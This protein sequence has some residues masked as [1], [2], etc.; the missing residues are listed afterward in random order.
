MPL[1]R[2]REGPYTCM[3]VLEACCALCVI[4]I[5]E[6][7]SNSRARGVVITREAVVGALRELRF[8][9]PSFP[10][11]A[12]VIGAS[13]YHSTVCSQYERWR[14]WPAVLRTL[15]LDRVRDTIDGDQIP[16]EGFWF[17]GD[18]ALPEV[19]NKDEMDQDLTTEAEVALDSRAEFRTSLQEAQAAGAHWILT[20]AGEVALSSWLGKPPAW[21]DRMAFSFQPHTVP[22]SNHRNLVGRLLVYGSSTTDRVVDFQ[23]FRLQDRSVSHGRDHHEDGT[24]CHRARDG[25]AGLPKS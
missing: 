24:S 8:P 10:E 23:L 14:L 18:T 21:A 5:S 15:W 11:I 19:K 13:R 12:S 25:A 22:G 4:D 9:V 6:I 3:Q 20:A 16:E 7:R 17:S 2:R 1:K